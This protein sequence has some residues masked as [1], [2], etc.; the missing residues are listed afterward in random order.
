VVTKEGFFPV[1]KAM[2]DEEL[3]ANDLNK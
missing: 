1:S 2:A 3:K